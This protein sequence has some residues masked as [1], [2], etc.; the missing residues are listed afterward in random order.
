MHCKQSAEMAEI[1][2]QYWLDKAKL[3]A[4]LDRT[5]FSYQRYPYYYTE[6]GLTW[7]VADKVKKIVP[8]TAPSLEFIA[9]HALAVDAHQDIFVYRRR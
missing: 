9:H 1:Y 5:G 7:I 6:Y 4:E 2:E 8:D 3:N